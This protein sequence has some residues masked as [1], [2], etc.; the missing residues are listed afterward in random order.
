MKRK[1]TEDESAGEAGGTSCVEH[2]T[3][4][5][6]CVASRRSL[7]SDRVVLILPNVCAAGYKAKKAKELQ[8]LAS[9]SHNWNMLFMRS[10]TGVCARACVR[11]VCCALCLCLSARQH[12]SQRMSLQVS[13]HVF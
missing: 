13:A 3:D 1:V 5:T 7:V 10:D 11:F 2:A 8:K 9:S 12:E 6:W 4:Q